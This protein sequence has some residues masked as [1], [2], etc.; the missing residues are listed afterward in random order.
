MKTQN[1]RYRDPKNRHYVFLLFSFVFLIIIVLFTTGSYAYHMLTRAGDSPLTSPYTPKAHMYKGAVH[2]HTANSYD[3]KETPKERVTQYS[4]AGYRFIAITEHSTSPDPD[5]RPHPVTGNPAIPGMLYFYGSE[6]GAKK[7]ARYHFH[8]GAFNIPADW[9]VS[10]FDQTR[11]DG[12]QMITNVT[13]VGG[14]AIVNHPNEKNQPLSD[15]YLYTLTGYQAIEIWNSLL[16][17]TRSETEG[18]AEEKWDTVLTKGKTVWGVAGD[19]CHR[20]AEDAWG[21]RHCM[22]SYLRVAADSLTREDIA[23]G[24]KSGNFYTGYTPRGQ[25]DI[26]LNIKVSG[27]AVSASTN[28]PVTLEFITRNG[29]VKKTVVNTRGATYIPTESDGY[30]RIRAGNGKAFAWSNPVFTSSES[31]VATNPSNTNDVHGDM[32][33]DGVITIVDYTLYMSAWFTKGTDADINGDG[34]IT[35]ADYTDFMN[36]W[37]AAKSR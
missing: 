24:I 5:F 8:L 13:D 1:R 33:G 32:N 14:I 34:N 15:E 2:V 4:N 3:G 26:E 21:G 30:V 18:R 37:N 25:A 35:V 16:V 20:M 10:N 29:Q 28:I 31:P 19:D 27:N 23:S 17:N 6:L 11:Y 22:T 36:A 9:D 7:T 12:Q